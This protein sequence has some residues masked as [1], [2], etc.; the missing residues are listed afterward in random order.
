MAAAHQISCKT[1]SGAAALRVTA[2]TAA[3]LRAALLR[4]LTA[5]AKAGGLYT[6]AAAGPPDGV[7]RRTAYI[8]IDNT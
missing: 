6:V 8:F 4:P 2:R 5:S 7:S 1:V 3:R